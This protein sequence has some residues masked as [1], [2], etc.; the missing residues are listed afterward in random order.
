MLDFL[1]KMI[2]FF[3][4]AV[5]MVVHGGHTVHGVLHRR[6]DFR[7]KFNNFNQTLFISMLIHSLTLRRTNFIRR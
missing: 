7:H 5:K 1:L 3:V 2:F 4:A 6:L